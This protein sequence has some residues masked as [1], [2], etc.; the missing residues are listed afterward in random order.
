MT[1]T[2]SG[3]TSGHFCPVARAVAGPVDAAAVVVA[4]QVEVRL[5]PAQASRCPV[6][7]DRPELTF[8]RDLAGYGWC[9]RSGEWLNVGLGRRDRRSFN[10]HLAGFVAELTTAGRIPPGIPAAWPGHAYLLRAGGPRRIVGDGLLL[11]G[12]AAGLACPASGEGILPAVVSG[13]LAA[14]VLLE[15][16]GD[17]RPER[18]LAYARRLEALLGPRSGHRRPGPLRALVGRAILRSPALVR[19][20]VLDRWFLHRGGAGLGAEWGRATARSA[21]HA[22]SNG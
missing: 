3:W 4:R 21:C 17:Y 6:E 1:S 18:L 8:C 9:V 2:P 16:A 20:L 13:R 15:A 11:V 10:H 14:E 12:D 19:H 5:T 7:E 22:P